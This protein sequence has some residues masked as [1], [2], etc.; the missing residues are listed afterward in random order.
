MSALYTLLRLNICVLSFNLLRL[1]ICVL[2][3][4]LKLN[5]KFTGFIK[6]LDQKIKQNKL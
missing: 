1:N 5:S 6:L 2:S 4:N 3:F